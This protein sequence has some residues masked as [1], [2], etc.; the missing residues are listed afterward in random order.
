M[1]R[2]TYTQP[3]LSGFLLL[4]F[5]GMVLQQRGRKSP[6]LTI[7]LFGLLLISWPPADWLLS[8]PLEAWY[9]IRPLPA[10]SATASPQVP[11]QAIVVLS[12]GV[13]PPLFERPYTLADRETYQRSLFAAWLH[14]HWQPLPVLACGG[15]EEPGEQPYSAVMRNIIQG[16][17]VP[18]NMLWTEERSH[19]THENAV[20][21]AE[22]LRL[23]GIH[24]IALVVDA[25][26][27][28]RAEACFRK[29]GFAVTPAPS[30]FC[31][32]DTHEILPSWKAIE[33]NELTLHETLGWAWYRLHG[34]I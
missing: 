18:D 21:G 28:L 23:H 27:M 12:A 25:Q 29:L 8:R 20:F 33:R 16:A 4:A 2:M 34:W 24:S 14:S 19:S 11:P 6:L 13:S 30:S 17:G 22:V 5:L 31:E 32:L 1:D 10:A 9:P 3:L 7:G 15:A 26:S